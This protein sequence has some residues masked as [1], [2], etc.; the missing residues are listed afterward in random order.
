MRND[1]IS[2]SDTHPCHNYCFSDIIPI[3]FRQSDT[4]YHLCPVHTF[5]MLDL[6][7]DV[8]AAAG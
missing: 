1:Y 7:K 5:D 6:S 3:L 8:K 2:V 4:I